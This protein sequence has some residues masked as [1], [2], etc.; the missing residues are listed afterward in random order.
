[1][2]SIE[3]LLFAYSFA[4]LRA[5]ENWKALCIVWQETIHVLRFCH[6]WNTSAS[7]RKDK[8]HQKT[9][10]RTIAVIV[11][12]AVN[13]FELAVQRSLPLVLFTS[14]G[15]REVDTRGVKFMAYLHKPIKPSQLYNALLSLFATQEQEQ[16]A[17][18]TLK[19]SGARDMCFD[20][21]LGQRLPLHLLLAEDNTVNQKLAL[22]L[23]ERMGYRADV[24]ANGLEVLE[25]VQRQQYDVI[26]M[27]VQRSFSFSQNVIPAHRHLHIKPLELFSFNSFHIR[28]IAPLIDV[29]D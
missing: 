11:Y 4:S 27:D 3:L 29:P 26:L 21:S 6:K 5:S 17:R 7:G 23:L 24:V 2:T 1:M 8:Q 22:R 10:M 20:T 13:P 19:L 18:P 25:A 14:L 9:A 16:A 12:D 28:V 15:R